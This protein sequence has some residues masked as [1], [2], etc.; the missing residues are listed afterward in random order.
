MIARCLQ[1]LLGQSHP[2]EQRI[3][4]DNA[5]S[6]GSIE[7]L[8]GI[9]PGLRVVR[10]SSNR[11]FSL[12]ANQG[13]AAAEGDWVLL[14]NQ[15]VELEADYLERLLAA[16]VLNDR[17][18]AVTGKL[19]RRGAVGEPLVD[20]TGHILY[21]NGWASNR[22][23]GLPDGEQWATPGTVFGVSAAAALYR[24]S[25]L[26]AVSDGCARP[27]DERYFAYIEDVDLDW[28]AAQLGWT[29]WYEP[30]VA[31]HQR[32][33]SGARRQ[34]ATMRR[35]LRNRL[36]TVANNDLWPEGLLHLPGV[37]A[38]TAMTALQFGLESPVAA[39]GV[40]DAV[41]EFGES[42]RRRLFL[43][44]RRRSSGQLA[45]RPRLEAFPYRRVLLGRF[46]GQ[47]R[48]AHS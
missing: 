16:G 32:G 12:A 33:A 24:V 29:A 1:T 5:S 43:R 27:F 40:L 9:D 7:R 10:N 39:L 28:R 41:R 48:A 22:G 3:V 30:A 26:R 34:P 13:I 11:G 2:A 18:G 8:L 23:E 38:L 44:T 14:L 19:M 17:I 47:R 36:L 25:M 45:A 4:V 21:R 31:W 35:I 6:D 20:S 46:R 42:R 15:D 37:C